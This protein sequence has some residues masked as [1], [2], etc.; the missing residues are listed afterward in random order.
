MP[1]PTAPSPLEPPERRRA[2]IAIAALL[3]ALDA[4]LLASAATPFD[5]AALMRS[6]AQVKAGE[7]TFTER[8]T[9]AMLDQTLES[10]GRLSFEAPDT[11]VRETLKPRRERL[12][13]AG[14]TLTISQGTRSRS[15]PLDSAPEAAVIVEA[16]RGTLTGNRETL[17]RYF[18]SAV[19]GSAEQWSLELVPLDARL[20]GQVAAVRVTGRQA[21][22]RQVEVLMSDGDRS[23]MTIQAVAAR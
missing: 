5:L 1:Q 19:S 10:S 6:L 14:N 9:V 20:R 23:L 21:I 22:V 8:R 7:A 4:P 3:C 17:D 12:A 15:M 11:F 18:S 13:V 16:I 2:I